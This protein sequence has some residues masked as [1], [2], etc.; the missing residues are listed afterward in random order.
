MIG[1]NKC[2]QT[3]SGCFF[4]A[5]KRFD[6]TLGLCGGIKTNEACFLEG[7]WH[8]KPGVHEPRGR[9]CPSNRQNDGGPFCTRV[10]PRGNS[11]GRN[12]RP[13]GLLHSCGRSSHIYLHRCASSRKLSRA[14]CAPQPAR[15]LKI[16][17]CHTRTLL[18]IVRQCVGNAGRHHWGRC[19]CEC[20][21]NCNTLT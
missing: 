21:F 5:A 15:C 17:L 3:D 20:R 6:S 18:G 7:A 12:R 10:Q 9:L 2:S 16:R 13:W 19:R 4:S 1:Q 8:L 14:V 11:W